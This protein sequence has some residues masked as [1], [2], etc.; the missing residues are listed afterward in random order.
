MALVSIRAGTCGFQP[1][2]GHMEMSILQSHP[3]SQ[4]FLQSSR[5]QRILPPGTL[6][7]LSRQLGSHTCPNA[8]WVP[9]EQ[10]APLLGRKAGP[11]VC[12]QLCHHLAEA[13]AKL[14]NLLAPGFPC[15]CRE[16]HIPALPPSS[17][18]LLG[19]SEM[20]GWN[21][22]WKRAKH[23]SSHKVLELHKPRAVGNIRVT[24]GPS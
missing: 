2:A 15:L 17:R 8:L 18:P 24:S 16:P 11:F 7:A 3:L 9:W 20:N 4:L 5:T 1:G 14:L 21:N 19:F 12:A 23:T 10:T 13:L 6:A 22:A